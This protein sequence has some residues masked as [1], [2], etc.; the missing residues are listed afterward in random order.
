MVLICTQHAGCYQQTSKQIPVD[1]Y[2]TRWEAWLLERE[3]YRTK[4]SA[5]RIAATL[6]AREAWLLER[7]EYRTK[8][9]A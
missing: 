3:E 4:P 2:A 5:R 8:S 6:V 1:M 7:E 9:S